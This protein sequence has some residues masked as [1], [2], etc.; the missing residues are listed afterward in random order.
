M[1]TIDA[2]VGGFASAYSTAVTDDTIRM[3][4]GTHLT[5]SSG[6]ARQTI[7]K[8]LIIQ[9]S[10][11]DS[12]TTPGRYVTGT[13][14]HL[15]TDFATIWEG[16]WNITAANVVFRG[17]AFD[18]RMSG[19][20][21]HIGIEADGVTFEDCRFT[22]GYRYIMCLIGSA[23][24]AKVGV[25]FRRCR[26][27]GIGR[28]TGNDHPIYLKTCRDTIIEDCIFYENAGWAFHCYTDC[29]GMIVRRTVVDRSNGGVV[30][31]GDSTNNVGDGYSTNNT[32]ETSIFTNAK[33]ITYG[34]SVNAAVSPRYLAEFEYPGTDGVNYIRTSD[35]WNDG[36]EPSQIQGTIESGAPIQVASTRINVNPQYANPTA[37]D[38]TLSSSSPAI[39]MGPTQI[40]PGGAPPVQ[41]P[42][43]VTNLAQTAGDTQVALTWTQSSTAGV[44]NMVRYSTT[45]FPANETE[46]TSAYSGVAKTSHTIT[47]LTNGTPVYVSVF[48][49]LTSNPAGSQYSDP[50]SIASTP[51]AGTPPPPPPPPPTE[52]A[53]GEPKFGKITVGTTWRGMSADYKRASR[54]TVPA[55]KQ[56]TAIYARLRG[57]VGSTGTQD[58]RA[59]AYNDATGALLGVS[60][61]QS[62]SNALTEAWVAFT[63]ASPIVMPS[64]GGLVRL[65]L[66]T[67]S[68][69]GGLQV[70]TD[71]VAGALPNGADT[72]SGGT[73]ASWTTF[74]N[75]QF[76]LS[77]CAVIADVA[78]SAVLAAASSWSW[79]S[80]ADAI[81]TGGSA[82]SVIPN[83]DVV[84]RM[85][86]EV[87]TYQ[88]PT[89]YQRSTGSKLEWSDGDNGFIYAEE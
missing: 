12:A 35:F 23:T 80:S 9:A 17:I 88:I 37:G 27:R 4:P 7:A 86:T 40:Q 66:H 25:T 22:D 2:A 59:F 41:R 61:D 31:A 65:G 54:F 10:N 89:P 46:G 78:A 39:G 57:T 60:A 38:F 75:D 58:I 84:Y 50:A 32:I 24:P 69:A 72:F 52:P 62:L 49:T 67:G 29:D 74:T 21:G 20:A 76:E 56:I 5:P 48:A 85:D 71:V 33:G 28:R 51:S 63:P 8:R 45:A 14:G 3:G 30:F 82:P 36:T 11:W 44:G 26:F 73:D 68:T 87:I 13:N 6:T 18:G 1:A 79:N 42:N 53:P 19:G 64:N 43:S 55:L 16:G 15:Q 83:S 77:I 47:G 70:A 81:E 34:S